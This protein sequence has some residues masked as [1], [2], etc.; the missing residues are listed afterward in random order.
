[1]AFRTLTTPINIPN[2]TKVEII[3]VNDKR[4]AAVDPHF[5]I[6]LH[7]QA[8][9]G[10]D[11]GTHTLIARDVAN[12]NPIR[13]NAAP[14]GFGDIILSGGVCQVDGA[15]TALA[16]AYDTAFDATVGNR[17]AKRRAGEAAALVEAQARGLIDA[18]LS[19]T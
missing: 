15:C 17:A 4:D 13:L 10:R 2:I 3:D 8:A 19:S 1:M 12:S 16:T 7:F 9:G 5:S 18:G 6:T 14:A 11:A